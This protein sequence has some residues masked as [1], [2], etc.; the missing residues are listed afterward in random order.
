[1]K[2]D[3]LD[4][5]VLQS[6]QPHQ[7]VAYLGKKHW[8]EQRHFGE[9]AT[10]WVLGNGSPEQAFEVLV[11]TDPEARDFSDR[12]HDVLQT[13]A[14][15]ENRSQEEI[16][17][18][19]VTVSVDV[20]RFRANHPF[21]A[22]DGSLP[23]E[24]GINLHK[25]ARNALAYAACSAVESKAFHDRKPQQA[26]Q[27]IRRLRLAQPQ[28]GSYILNIISPL[29]SA[30][31]ELSASTAHASVHEA[32]ERRVTEKLMSALAAVEGAAK[33][34]RTAQDAEI[35]WKVVRAGVSANLCDA[36]LGLNESA[37]NQGVEVS[38]NWSASL[39]RPDAPQKVHLSPS[40]MPAIEAAANL[41]RKGIYEDF[42]VRG[43][44]VKLQLPENETIGTVTVA[45][46]V[47]DRRKN[48]KISLSLKE[49]ELAIRAHGSDAEVI[50]RG[51]L[52]KEG[53]SYV[54]QNPRGFALVP[55]R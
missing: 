41:L 21:A 26:S 45:C 25:H 53:S 5:K 55:G 40:L 10:I 6:V 38:L 9:R 7:V 49:Y 30:P 31:R 24:D 20:V 44:V 37:G 15:A 3:I 27:Y 43:R 14:I 12:I 34:V 16:L 46:I 2:A 36:I 54:L 11:P 13:L 32:F 47:D 4:T 22:E 17:F 42:E 29:S 1:M 33:Q 19:L 39:P 8:H 18:D 52:L 51:N 35:F 50:C 28:E 48:V 23:L